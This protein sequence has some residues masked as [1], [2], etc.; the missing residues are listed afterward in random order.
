MDK[1]EFRVLIKYCFLKGKNTVEAKTWLDATA[2]GQFPAK[3]GR[4]GTHYRRRKLKLNEI[5]DP[6]KILIERVHHIIHEYLGMRKFYAKWVPRELTFKTHQKQRVDDSEQCLKMIK[7]NKPELLRRY[8]TMDKTDPQRKKFS[9]IEEVI[10]ETE[11][12]FEAKDKS[13]YKNG[14]EKIEGRY[15]QCTAIEGNYVE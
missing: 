6:L 2:P 12:C 11:S 8:A 15:N 10:G 9:S 13:Y 1:K 14:I 4:G 5:A 7:R 3:F